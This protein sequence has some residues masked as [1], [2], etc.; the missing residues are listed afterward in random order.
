MTTPCY[1]IKNW[2]EIYENNRTRE[3]KNMLWLPLPI[4]LNGD[5]FTLMMQEKDGLEIFGA[6]IILLEI[7]ASCTPRGTLVRSNGEPHDEK[8]MERISRMK[9]RESRRMLRYCSTTLKW[10]ELI[11]LENGAVIPQEGATIPQEPALQEGRKDST[12]QE[13]IIYKK[14][15]H[16]KIT[17]KECEKLNS[18]GYSKSQID[19]ILLRIENYKKNKNYNS[20]YLTALNWL[21]RDF[22]NQEN[23]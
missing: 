13:G 7:A 15:A 9:V 17:V 21:K 23:E 3:L 10:L 19:D 5:G 18:F 1:R 6:F 4:K 2:D 16:L 12:K 14:F 20:L 8:T 11:D 22:G